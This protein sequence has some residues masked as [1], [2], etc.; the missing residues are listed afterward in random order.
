M[1]AGVVDLPNHFGYSML[2]AGLDHLHH[3]TGLLFLFK[4]TGVVD[5]VVIHNV[6]TLGSK[7]YFAYC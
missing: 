6:I 4:F 3:T 2:V 1:V 7:L 5:K